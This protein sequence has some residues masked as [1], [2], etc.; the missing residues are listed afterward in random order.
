MVDKF[1]FRLAF[2]IVKSFDKHL[3]FSG[4]FFQRN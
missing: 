3:K 4:F 1:V 2:A